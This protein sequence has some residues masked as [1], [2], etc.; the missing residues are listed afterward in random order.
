MAANENG[1]TSVAAWR[2]FRTL[3]NIESLE[4]RLGD[5]AGDG[6]AVLGLELGN[7][8]LSDGTDAA[9][10]GSGIVAAPLEF[11]LDGNLHGISG[12]N[13]IAHIIG[14]CDH[15]P[16]GIDADRGDIDGIDG[17]VGGLISAT[18]IDVAGAIARPTRA[19]G[20]VASAIG[21]GG[22]HA[23]LSVTSE[24]LA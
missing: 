15:V 11:H 24:T 19:R 4:Q 20:A 12:I 2:T 8:G 18:A 22:V 1:A 3:R 7:G 21:P 17:D 6:D 9:I 10:D 5:G 16:A 14:P 23:A 13:R